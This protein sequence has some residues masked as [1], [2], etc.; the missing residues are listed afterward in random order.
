[1]S[2]DFDRLSDDAVLS[3][4]TG[5]AVES[6]MRLVIEERNGE[7]FAESRSPS[8]LGGEMVVLGA[9]GTRPSQGDAAARA[10]VR[11]RPLISKSFRAQG[12]HLRLEPWFS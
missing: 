1:V 4:L 3:Y 2:D 9:N 6:D 7:W 10:T 12:C 5:A 11:R 8:G